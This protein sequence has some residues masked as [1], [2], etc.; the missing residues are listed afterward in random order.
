MQYRLELWIIGKSNLLHG[1]SCNVVFQNI[2]TTDQYASAARAHFNNLL[3]Y[4][5][6]TIL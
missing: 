5:K 3:S 4:Y 1:V 6:A 2:R